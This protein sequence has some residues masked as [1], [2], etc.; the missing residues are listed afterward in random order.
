MILAAGTQLGP[1]ALR[2]KLND[3]PHHLALSHS[4]KARSRRHAATCAQLTFSSSRSLDFVHF[5]QIIRCK[6]SSRVQGISP[7]RTLSIA[8][9]YPRRHWSVKSTQLIFSPLV[10]PSC[11]FGNYGTPPVNDSSEGVEHKL[12]H[13]LARGLTQEAY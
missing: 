5:Q 7:L 11:G 9:L 10:L 12:S 3:R 4:G 6:S 2:P 8:G 1:G 13:S